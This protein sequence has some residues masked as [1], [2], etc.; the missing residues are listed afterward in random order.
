MSLREVLGQGVSRRPITREN[1]HSSADDVDTE[2]AQHPSSLRDRMTSWLSQIQR[3]PT[4]EERAAAERRSLLLDELNKTVAESPDD[5][6]IRSIID[7]LN[8]HWDD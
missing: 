8:H 1:S 5:V 4:A 6:P 7:R 2:Q 3:D